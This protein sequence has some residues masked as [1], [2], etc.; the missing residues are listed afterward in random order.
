MTQHQ[1]LEG[2]GTPGSVRAASVEESIDESD[3]S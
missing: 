1:G 2:V 3:A